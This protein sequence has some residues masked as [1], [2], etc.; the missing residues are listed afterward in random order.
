M[1]TTQNE[2]PY[3]DAPGSQ[4]GEVIEQHS[5]SKITCDTKGCGA[6]ERR[7][8]LVDMRG[9]AGWIGWAHSAG[10]DYCPRCNPD[11]SHKLKEPS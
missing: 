11:Y 7:G 9:I 5:F 6:N 3:R 10:K 8:R 1:G 2:R 4:G